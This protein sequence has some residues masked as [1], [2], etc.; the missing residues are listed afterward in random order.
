[1][2]DRLLHLTVAIFRTMGLWYEY[3]LLRQTAVQGSREVVVQRH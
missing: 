1:M 3:P 2:G